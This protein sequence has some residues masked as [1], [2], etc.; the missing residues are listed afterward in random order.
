MILCDG[1]VV[2]GQACVVYIQDVSTYAMAGEAND[3]GHQLFAC[4]VVGI[5]EPLTE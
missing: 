5:A 3:V 2:S 4:R 1:W